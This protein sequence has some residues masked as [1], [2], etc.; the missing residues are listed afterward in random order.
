MVSCRRA[1]KS[2]VADRSEES[3]LACYAC[4]GCCVLLASSLDGCRSPG[5]YAWRTYV[6][7]VRFILK[8]VSCVTG[9]RT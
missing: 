3:N 7:Y 1:P 4:Q 2:R 5:I 6:R 8:Y 9:D